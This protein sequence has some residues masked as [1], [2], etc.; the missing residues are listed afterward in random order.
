MYMYMSKNSHRVV[1]SD[2]AADQDITLGG[3]E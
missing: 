1:V 2:E 3:A